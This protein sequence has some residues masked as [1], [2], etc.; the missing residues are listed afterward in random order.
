MSSIMK[1]G[2]ISP[3][4]VRQIEDDL[5]EVIAGHHRLEATRRLGRLSV[6]VV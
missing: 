4:V 2:V 6:P 5:F 1:S 3:I